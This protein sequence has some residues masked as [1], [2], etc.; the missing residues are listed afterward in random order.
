MLE[1]FE[2]NTP[3][4]YEMIAHF[5]HSEMSIAFSLNAV[6]HVMRHYSCFKI[7]TGIRME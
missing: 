1:Y 2:K 5:I 4:T 6:R 7:G 3:A